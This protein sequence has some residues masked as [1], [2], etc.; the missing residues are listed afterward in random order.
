MALKTSEDETFDD[1]YAKLNDTMDSK[2]NIGERVYWP[3]IVGNV[4]CSLLESFCP[5]V[6]ARENLFK[7]HSTINYA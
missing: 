2:F 5:R 6:V 3:K 7:F 1:F 4:L